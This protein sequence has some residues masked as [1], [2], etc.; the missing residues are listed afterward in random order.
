MKNLKNFH[1]EGF[2]HGDIRHLNV[3]IVS[4]NQTQTQTQ[5]RNYE[6]KDNLR[7][8]LI[9]FDWSGRLNQVYFPL[10]INKSNY[11]YDENISSGKL[12]TLE[13]DKNSSNN[14]FGKILSY[15]NS[16]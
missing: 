14:L 12:I 13:T 8:Y 5:T 4:Q 16:V 2:V 6:Y 3:M 11:K 1:K 10:A 7:L 9:D 15:D